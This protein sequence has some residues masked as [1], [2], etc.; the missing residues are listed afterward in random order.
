VILPTRRRPHLLQRVAQPI[1]SVR[2]QTGRRTLKRSAFLCHRPSDPRPDRRPI[3][4]LYGNLRH[5]RLAC[6]SVTAHPE[7]ILGQ[8]LFLQAGE[9]VGL[10]DCLCRQDSSRSISHYLGD[11]IRQ[12]IHQLLPIQIERH[13]QPCLQRVQLDRLASSP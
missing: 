10:E 11:F 7:H 2:Y 8:T 9:E 6:T 3:S 13:S 4:V 12:L 5:P 1:S